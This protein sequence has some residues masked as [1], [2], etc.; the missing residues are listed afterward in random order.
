MRRKK[1]N[2]LPD[3]FW[4]FVKENPKVVAGLAFQLG[5]WAGET[6]VDIKAFKRAGKIPAQLLHNI[7]HGVSEAALR[8]L[9]SPA[10]Q[11]NDVKARARR[12]KP[13]GSKAAVSGSTSTMKRK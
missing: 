8:L 1:S 6:T 11:P 12:R 3:I 4:N 2:S 10:L 7:P 5:V 9:P 13:N